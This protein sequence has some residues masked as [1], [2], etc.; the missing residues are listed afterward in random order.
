[1]QIIHFLRFHHVYTDQFIDGA[2]IQLNSFVVKLRAVDMLDLEACGY[3]ARHV[4]VFEFEEI[5][6]HRRFVQ[7]IKQIAS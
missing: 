2:R 4:D 6:I 7:R 3:Y 5:A 1:M